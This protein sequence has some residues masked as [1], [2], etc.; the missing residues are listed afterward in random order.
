[1]TRLKICMLKICILLSISFVFTLISN[2]QQNQTGTLQGYTKTSGQA[3]PGTTVSIKDTRMGTA[4]DVSGF[5]QMKGIPAGKYILLVSSL[6]YV[7]I[8]DTIRIQAGQTLKLDLELEEA[9]TE[10][11]TVT[12]FGKSAL[13]ETKELAYEVQAI[14]AKALHNTT[15]DLGHT[16][17]RVSGV[18]VRETGGVGSRM[19]FSLNGFTGRQVKFFIDGV[20]MDNFGSSFQLNNIPVNLA[21]RIEIYKGVVP[22]WLGSDALGGAVNIVT[23]DNLRTYLDASYAYGSFNTHRTVVNAGYTSDAGFTLQLNA[24]QNYSDNN[25]WVDV[26]VAD[27]NSGKYYPDQRVRRFHDTYHNETIIAKLGIVDKSFADQMLVGVT[28]GQNYSE[29]QTGARLV[30]VF[31]DWHRRGNILMPTFKY[32]KTDLLLKGLDLTMNANYNFGTEQNIDTVYRRYNWFGEYKQYEG[33]GSERSRSMY[34]YSNNNGVVTANLNYQISDRQAISL[35]HV[36]NTFNRK[37][38]DALYP[39]NDSYDQPRISLKNISG[40]GY[41]YELNERWSTS[42]FVK[43]YAQTNR[44]S[45]VYNPS[46]NWGDEAY[47]EQEN[48]FSKFG[49]GAAS[50]FFINNHLQ[51]KAS[52]EKSYR[53]PETEELYGDLV[54]LQGNIALDPETSNNFNLGASFQTSINKAH[55]FSFSSN[56]LY[57]DAEDFIRARLNNNQTMQVMD[58]LFNVT[59]AGVDGEIRYSYRRLLTAGVNMTYQNLR[60]NTKYEDGQ[61]TESIVYRDRIPNM[62]YLFGNTDLS[63]FLRDLWKAGDALTLSYNLLYVHAFYLYWPSLGSD[64]LDIPEQLSHDLSLTYAMADGKYNMTVEC[65]NLADAKLYD[66]FSLQKP[67]RSFMLKLRYFISQ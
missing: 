40:L 39:E 22:I 36:Y 21:E 4:S 14:N 11:E 18:R 5:Y 55:Q 30:S 65:R 51:L 44:Y 9:Y 54:N 8:S 15:L 7:T 61:S 1:M 32:K 41:K 42:I 29:I 31:G 20:P 13:Q 17:D 63:F 2:A 47:L 24:F 48:N 33:E 46:G 60:N 45:Q 16:L 67:G 57:R 58:N 53:L 28:L 27:I 26:D 49:Y 19:N 66:N 12:V 64:K 62:P 37:G 25:Y 34:K 35:N 3:L 10:L 6:G 59:N 38:S 56:I 23:N 43:H 52:Y 50:T